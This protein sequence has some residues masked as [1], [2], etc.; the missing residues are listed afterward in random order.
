MIDLHIHSTF[1]DG[2]ETPERIAA[3]ARQIGLTAVALTDHDNMAGV[4]AFMQACRREGIT[5]FSGVEISAALDEEY[6]A[7]TLHLLG[8]GLDPHNPELQQLLGR[9]LDGRAWRNEQIMAKL[10]KIGVALDWGAVQATAAE[11]VIGRPHIAQAMVVGNYVSSL[12]EAFEL[13][14]AK[15]APA[16]VDRYRLNP[17]QAIQAI[18]AAGGLTFVAH[19]FTWIDDAARLEHELRHL[20]Q[21]GLAGIEAYHSDHNTE[22]TVAL[23]RVAKKLGLMVSGGSDFHGACKP[24]IRLGRGRGNLNIASARADALAEALGREKTMK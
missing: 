4:P 8:Y 5:A 1:S 15:G 12:Q 10:A 7:S 17:E 22:E 21:L 19:P 13:Y 2:S 24:L 16:Y 6:A 23:L 14:L 11:N 20:Q 9:V 3:M 18:K